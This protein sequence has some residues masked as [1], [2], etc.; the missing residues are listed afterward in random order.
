MHRVFPIERR[1]V[2]A[3]RPV[4]TR[5]AGRADA[6]GLASSTPS[7]GCTP[8]ST[9]C[10]RCSPARRPS[11]RL[12]LTPE[13]VVLAEARRS[14]TTLSLFGYRVDGVVANRVFPAEGADDWRAGWVVAQD[15]VLEPGRGSPSPGCRCGARSTG[16]REPVGVRGADRP[17]RRA[18]RRRRPA[19]VSDRRRAVPGRR[20]PTA[21][22]CSTSRCRSSPG[23]RSTSR[24]TATSWWSPSRRGSGER[25]GIVSS[26]AHPAGG[27]GEA[28]GRRAPGWSGGELQ[29]RFEERAR[30]RSREQRCGTRGR[31]G[32]QPRGR[33]RR[34]QRRRGGG[35]A[36][37]RAVRLGPRPRRRP[38]PRVVRG[39]PTRRLPPRARSATTSTPGAPS[40]RT[41]RSAA[42]CTLCAQASPEVREPPDRGRR[43]ADAGRGRAAGHGRRG[44]APTA[45]PTGVEHIDL[46]EGQDDLDGW[47]EDDAVSLA[48]GI[49]V[50][51]TKI[52]GG[53]VDDDGA[54]LEELRV[55]S[56]ADRRRGDR[57][58]DRRPGRASC[59]SRHD[60]RGGRR[61]RRRLR[62]QGPAR[63][64]LF[65]PNLA[66]RDVA[67]K[68]E[69]EERVD[70]PVV[71]ENDAN[72]AAW[73]EFAFGAGHDVDD[74]LL[75]T[76]GTG[77]GGGLVLDGELYR[78]GVRRR[79]RDRPPP[80]WCRTASAA[81]AATAAASSSTPAARRWSARRARPR[82]RQTPPLPTACSSGRR[83]PRRGHHGP[84]ITE[85]AQDG[86]PFA[87][88][89]LAA[90]GQ[91]ARRR[92]S[93]RWPP[94]STRPW[95]RSAAAS[96]RPATCCST[97]SATRSP[98]T[99][100]ARAPAARRDPHGRA[101][102]RRRHDRRRRP[103]P[104]PSDATERCIGVDVGGTK[105]LAGVVDARRRGRRAPRG[106][107]PGRL[108]PAPDVEDALVDAVP[109]G[110]RRATDRGG[111]ASR[112]PG[113]STRRVSG[114]CSPRT[115]PGAA[116]TCATGSPRRW[117]CR[118]C[119]TTTPPA[120]R[121]AEATY[122]AGRG[123]SSVVLVTLG[124]RHRR[125]ARARRPGVARRQRHGGRVRPHAGRAGRLAVR[126]RRA[127]LLGAVLQRQRAASATPGRG[128]GPS[129]RC[130]PSCAT[131]TRHA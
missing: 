65:A 88:E 67:L 18:V 76:V 74:L 31:P 109:G 35:Q 5:A 53:V 96:A 12:V 38:R 34:R 86:D 16:P 15:A 97:R 59:A 121:Y 17:R 22:P 61:R 90:L 99:S 32:G 107:T 25:R 100:R 39:S 116:R 79:R 125:R 129:P 92:A 112:R 30:R 94:C 69:L 1:V 21:A 9:R 91:L 57:G 85:A 62:R 2:K 72:A 11:V 48:C 8:S 52:A 37:R 119:S 75:V 89:Q 95:S 19:G 70:L 87:I 23:P 83:R 6:R 60:D 3:L 46:D 106:V 131:A 44:P 78:G 77:V 73:G 58:R 36:V 7:S 14:Y 54:V 20:A 98:R 4:L 122:G 104:R 51:G 120:R 108:A 105:V 93:P 118:S 130:S 24:A 123:A 28:T 27:A 81:A 113:S 82:P 47:P 43:V 40:A 84:V 50:G 114:S 63:A 115:C 55:E 102:Q 103:R 41:A 49:D 124:H 56:P 101:R 80:R 66:W 13:K 64:V 33:R 42:R 128:S 29:V 127:R 111:R 26:A 45:R 110:G 68:A 10:G 126:V 71:V 117:G